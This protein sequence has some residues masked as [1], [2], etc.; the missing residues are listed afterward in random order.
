MHVCGVSLSLGAAAAEYN[1]STL[2]SCTGAA[3]IG[4]AAR[5]AASMQS[6]SASTSRHFFAVGAVLKNEAHSIKEW[7]HHYVN[8]GASAFIFLDDNSTD[9]SVSI[10]QQFF[11]ATPRISS[12][13]IPRN[14]AKHRYV[15]PQF[16]SEL[17]A[18]VEQ[19]G[20]E[21]LL[22]ADLDEFAYCRLE[23]VPIREM[24]RR[25][26]YRG[27]D[28]VH[29]P[30]LVFG[31]NGL[32]RTS[33]SLVQSFTRRADYDGQVSWWAGPKHHDV[34]R[35]RW[36]WIARGRSVSDF[37]IHNCELQKGRRA[38]CSMTN[39]PPRMSEAIVNKFDIVVNHYQVQSR[40][41][42]RVKMARGDSKGVKNVGALS[43]TMVWFNEHN[44]H[45][46]ALCDDTLARRRQHVYWRA[47]K[48][49]EISD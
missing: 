25:D 22:V 6:E 49:T 16:Y 48:R 11:A 38:I 19:M 45:C 47:R 29:L 23:N 27:A 15:Q 41:Y 17:K 36:K 24:L 8:E 7:L 20:V 3:P 5:S 26:R 34:S 43:R 31:A 9:A 13:F 21:W 28:L 39:C 18:Y 46:N 32:E 40:E 35:T 44:K 1:Q 30:W 12:V 37:G 42:W 4:M 33:R 10:A 2:R 14:A